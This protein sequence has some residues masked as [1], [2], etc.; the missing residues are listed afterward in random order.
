[1]KGSNSLHYIKNHKRFVTHQNTFLQA[2]HFI[3]RKSVINTAV[4]L[5]MLL[6]AHNFVFNKFILKHR[7]FALN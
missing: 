6:M 7:I 2:S 3:G 1:M 5:A 4:M